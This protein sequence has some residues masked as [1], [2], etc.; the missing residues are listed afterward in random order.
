MYACMYVCMY[1]RTYVR[2]H[3]C[4][5]SCMCM[6]SQILDHVSICTDAVYPT[7][8]NACISYDA[9]ETPLLNVQWQVSSV[10]CTA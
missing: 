10:I 7:N 6:Y 9:A 8:V 1:V 3:A 2:M 4:M 5:C